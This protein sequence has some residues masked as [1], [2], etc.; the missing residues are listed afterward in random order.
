MWIYTYTKYPVLTIEC[1]F[2]TD[3]LYGLLLYLL[4]FS[5][6]TPQFLCFVEKD[7]KIFSIHLFASRN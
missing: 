1:K 2:S 4:I 5:V 7:L 3:S 6:L